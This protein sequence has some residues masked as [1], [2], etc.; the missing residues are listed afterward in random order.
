MTDLVN[1]YKEYSAFTEKP[2]TDT[3]LALANMASELRDQG[4]HLGAAF[5]S[6]AGH[7]K[8][9]GVEPQG[10]CLQFL[11]DTI[12]DLLRFLG[13]DTSANWNRLLT[14]HLLVQQCRG[15]FFSGNKA[16][17][18]AQI[19]ES[20]QAE[21]YLMLNRMAQG[22]SSADA[23]LMSGF[24]LRGCLDS[25]WEPVFPGY[26]VMAGHD[27]TS[28]DG[29]RTIGMNSG[30][31]SLLRLG[32]YDGALRISQANEQAL[33]SPGLRGWSIASAALL[34]G[35]SDRFADASAQFSLDSSDRDDKKEPHWSG[36]NQQLWAPYFMSR[37]H[38]AAPC[39]SPE[40]AIENLRKASGSEL[41][42]SVWHVPQ[43]NCYVQII[44]AV[45]GFADGDANAVTSAVQNY[46]KS[47]RWDIPSSFDSHVVSFLDN[48][49]AL[50]CKAFGDDWIKPLSQLL[51]L[52]DRLPILT[53]GEKENI[54]SA[55]NLAIPNSLLGLERGWMYESLASIKDEKKLHRILLAIFRA[56]AEVPEFSHIRH[57][58]FEYGKDIVVCREHDGRRILWMYSV[59]VGELKK[60]NWNRDIRPQLEEMFHVPLDSPE[61][62]GEIDERVGVLV[63]NN[64]ISPHA[65][66]IVKGWLEEQRRK[67]GRRFEL[68]NIDSLVIYVT[69]N[70]L[71]GALRKALR[72]EG[73]LS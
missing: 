27:S 10:L 69:E 15:P 63:W 12:N 16:I 34:I 30:F 71:G 37:S 48:I 54:E 51:R 44:S 8:A 58:A 3:A 72:L 17:Q 11:E 26:E 18:L 43:V 35:D 56:E 45:R 50:S 61:I 67:I 40:D 24:E 2:S 5:C 36:I 41:R 55:L 52:L 4:R 25:H 68:M 23:L 31:R 64:H 73:L 21:Y 62:P 33:I 13:E 42:P 49:Q 70:G 1:Q 53:T 59:K 60:A 19:Q 47:L 66:P 14:L 22:H 29:T 6:M 46:Q 39:I 65:D 57:G 20:A 7:Q 32:D 28:H 9:W 38:M